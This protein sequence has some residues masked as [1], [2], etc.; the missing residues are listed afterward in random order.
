[1]VSSFV[2]PILD[3]FALRMLGTFLAKKKMNWQVV[4]CQFII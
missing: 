1:M 4:V 2:Q 3:A